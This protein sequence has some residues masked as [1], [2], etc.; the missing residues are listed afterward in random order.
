MLDPPLGGGSWHAGSWSVV[1][2]SGHTRTGAAHDVRPPFVKGP[3]GLAGV[4]LAALGPR[5]GDR[6]CGG[7]RVLG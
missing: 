7:V 2:G 6:A 5:P 4:C 1:P 3:A